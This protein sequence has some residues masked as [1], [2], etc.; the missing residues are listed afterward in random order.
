MKPNELIKL[1]D[2]GVVPNL[3]IS[4]CGGHIDVNPKTAPFELPDYEI[5]RIWADEYGGICVLLSDGIAAEREPAPKM[6]PDEK[7]I[8][9]DDA[10][11]T[12]DTLLKYCSKTQCSKCIFEREIDGCFAAD[13][14]RNAKFKTK[15]GK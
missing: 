11:K 5:V 4:Y 7:E 8:S 2:S 6:T 3:R 1:L 14:I 13:F 10:R 15:E 12:V 9:D